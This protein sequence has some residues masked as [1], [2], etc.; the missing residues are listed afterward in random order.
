MVHS[1][2]QP[3][4]RDARAERRTRS[5][6]TTVIQKTWPAASYWWIDAVGGYLTFT[7]PRVMI[8]QPG[9]PGVD[10]PILADLSSRHAEIVRGQEGLVLVPL[11]ETRVNGQTG[12]GFLLK[13]GDRITMRKVELTY[14]QPLAWCSTARLEMTSRHRM[15]LSLDGI[16]LLGETCL[17]GPAP[18]AHVP[19]P[20]LETVYLRWS[21]QRYW[22]KTAGPLLIDGKKCAGG[23]PLE[24]NS[25]VEG[26]WG[27]FRWEP[28]P[29]SN[30][31]AP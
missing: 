10:L 22:I 11:A 5:R 27:S 30:V 9:N 18:D 1:W 3:G 31:T 29:R 24:P 16:I 15:P 6:V 21:R 4:S 8:G 19:A 7:K 20:W 23:G 28:V 14:R 17:I 12:T 26:P 25:R 2:S 13:D